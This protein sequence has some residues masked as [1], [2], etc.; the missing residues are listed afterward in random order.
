V[1]ARNATI[2]SPPVPPLVA[3]VVLG[4]SPG[5]GAAGRCGQ[6]TFT[7]AIGTRFFP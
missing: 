3:T 1:K 7:G 4:T 6:I 2:G 5:A